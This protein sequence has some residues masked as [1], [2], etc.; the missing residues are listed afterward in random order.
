[1]DSY[2]V[3][4]FEGSMETMLERGDGV[5]QPASRFKVLVF[6]VAYEAEATLEKVL[7]RIPPR[8]FE[9]ETE[10]LV[11]DDSSRDRTF[12]VGLRSASRSAQR[13]T[14]LYNSNNQGYGG[15]Q[16]L[17][18]AYA[19]RHNFDFVVL[20]H[21]DG[22][23]ASQCIPDLLQPLIDGRADAVL[24]S[25]MLPRGGAL[26]GGM[27]LYKF[28]GNQILTRTQNFVLRSDL[29]EFHS[30]FRAY[31]VATLGRLPF[32]Y[33]SNAFHFDTEIIIQFMLAGCRILEVPIPT[34]YG[35]EICRVNGVRYAID[36]VL[37]TLASRLHRLGI[38]YERKFDVEGP[39][40]L[41]YRLKLGYRSS[42][43]MA[44]E[45]VR[46]GERVLDIGCGSGSFAREL[47]KK[48][49][50]V[51]GVDKYLPAEPDVFESFRV[52]H[53]EEPWNLDLRD[54]DCVLL[55][56]V[57]EHLKEPEKFLDGLRHAARSLRG[58]PR[59]IVTTG[60]VAFGIVRLQMLLGN[61]NYGKRGILDLTHTRLYTLRTLRL[62]FEQCGFRVESVLGVP[63]P[64]PE[65]LGLNRLSR[66]LVWLNDALIRVARGFF[67]YQIFMV[68]TPT[69][70]VDV[71]LD[72]SIVGSR[73]K[74]A[75]VGQ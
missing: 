43:T 19:L 71:L 20:L 18:Y 23:Y 13:I 15:N 53:E 50:S 55:L 29:S 2:G 17:G 62:L 25:R 58:E 60:N 61:F 69:P 51:V 41:H 57:I 73:E 7:A 42:H 74:A 26:N 46:V 67:S 66:F 3:V 48:R 4:V 39:G 75:A 49:C 10:V 8:A 45:A 54:F 22:Q 36:V 9:F 59:F 14:I 37:A 44:L 27:P 31:R 1:M 34:Y 70:T 11:I 6:V 24:G 72:D 28:L 21:G 32:Q 5:S 33:N 56:D 35:E 16:K 65:A 30:G 68:V 40:N 52:W 64:F 38:L 12:E 47:A 63:A